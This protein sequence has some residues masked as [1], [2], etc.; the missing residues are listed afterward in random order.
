MKFHSQRAMRNCQ[1]PLAAPRSTPPGARCCHWPHRRRLQPDAPQAPRL[2]P[3]EFVLTVTAA[4]AAAA[5]LYWHS[6][7]CPSMSLGVAPIAALTGT[8]A[9]WLQARG[10]V[11]L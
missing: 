11:R 10:P 7:R 9:A 4:P 6:P 2:R 8:A 1:V 3:R 5:V